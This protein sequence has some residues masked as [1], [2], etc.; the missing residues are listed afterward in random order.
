MKQVSQISRLFVMQGFVGE[1]S[2]F[3]GNTLADG[4][5]VK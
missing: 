3:E 1:A 5:P 4:K 2:N